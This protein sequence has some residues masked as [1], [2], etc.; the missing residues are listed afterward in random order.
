MNYNGQLRFGY[1]IVIDYFS[2]I[3]MHNIQILIFTYWLYCY[4]RDV[5]RLPT[6]IHHVYP[7]ENCE[8]KV[9]GLKYGAI[10]SDIKAEVERLEHGCERSEPKCSDDNV[11]ES[12]QTAVFGLNSG[13][14]IRRA[15]TYLRA[16]KDL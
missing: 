2:K 13:D 5:I 1:T 11:G 14:N 12:E 10:R 4:F 6:T 8:A 3:T 9:F 15:P 16:K 7:D